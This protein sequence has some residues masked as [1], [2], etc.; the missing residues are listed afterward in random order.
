MVPKVT[1]P[2]PSFKDSLAY[3]L[4]DKAPEGGRVPET[5]DRVAWTE[6]R[7]FAN[8]NLDPDLAGRIM[9]ATAMDRDRLKQQAGIKNTG[10][11]PSDDVVYA[12]SLG[13]SD[14]ENG[15]ISKSEMLRAADESIRVLGAQD[16]QAI[17]VCH[18]DRPHPHVH[19][20]LNRVSPEDGRMLNINRD[21]NRL[22][23]WA[24][25]YRRE[26]GEEHIYCPARAA[27]E[28]AAKRTAAGETVDYVRGEK[29]MPRGLYEEFQKAKDAG[30][31]NLDQIKERESRLTAELSKK[32]RAMHARHSQEWN[33]LSADHQA[34]KDAIKGAA[35]DSIQR[36]IKAIKDSYRPAW[37]DLSR[38]QWFEKRAFDQRELKI[39]GRL[40]N[41]IDALILSKRH[42]G[43]ARGLV[44]R[45]YHYAVTKE[46]RAAALSQIHTAQRKELGAAQKAEI[47]AAIR[48]IKDDR[49][50]Q[51]TQAGVTFQS[52]RAALIERQASDKAAMRS[53]WRRRGEERALAF[54]GATADAE[55][56]QKAKSDLKKDPE[57]EAK[58]KVGP[59]RFKAASSGKP[60]SQGRARSRKRTRG[61]GGS[62]GK[63]GG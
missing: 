1:R 54:K 22:E 62:G 45:V 7:G 35:E 49:G 14:Q 39:L 28:E 38:A 12:Y 50:G 6:V 42:D 3:Y 17:I 26:R 5:S 16:H 24:L 40:H 9:M 41:A 46:G 59:K 52:S 15:K 47:D 31:V 44:S 55:A 32:S 56:R 13:W 34:R 11:K 21:Y 4:H 57:L 48:K 10:R 53:A 25:A 63:A 51:L 43:D 18:T 36:T 33:K 30:A 19:V 2:N 60:R 58:A 37:R 20:I 8:D 23:K 61:G 27:K 29:S